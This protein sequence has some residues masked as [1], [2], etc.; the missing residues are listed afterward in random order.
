MGFTN[1]IHCFLLQVLLTFP[2]YFTKKK[3][4]FSST[5]NGVPEN[6]DLFKVSI[7]ESKKDRQ[8]HFE[9]VY[10]K[11]DKSIHFTTEKNEQK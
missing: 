10:E 8:V 6:P 11:L 5:L 2:L 1:S 9:W 3:K 7:V 4:V